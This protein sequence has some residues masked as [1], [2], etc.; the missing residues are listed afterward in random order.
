MN[1]NKKF[2]L[3]GGGYVLYA[4]DYPRFQTAPGFS[5]E[6]HLY[7]TA[8][9]PM[10]HLAFLDAGVPL[11]MTCTNQEFVNG[12]AVLTFTDGKS[13][14]VVEERFVTTDD[15]CVSNVKMEVS[16]KEEREIS[17]V[18]WT[19]TDV[20]G[21]APSL[22]GDS[23]RVRRSLNAPDGTAIPVEIIWSSPSS[24]GAKCLQAFHG[25]GGSDR[26]DYEETPWYDMGPEFPTP[27]AKRPMQKPS[28]I[29]DEA[30]CYLGLFRINKLKGVNKAEHRFEANVVFKGSGINYRPRRPDPKD[31][32]NYQ[33]LM[34]KAP[35]FQ[36]ESKEIER[37]VHA[38]YRV[39][40]LEEAI[41]WYVDKF[42][43][44]H[45]GGGPSRSGG[46]NA[47]VNFGQVQVEL[48]EPGDPATMGADHAMDH[49]GY[50]VGDIPSCI[51]TCEA[52]GLKFVSDT[53]NT[54]SVGQQVLYFDTDTSMGSRMHLTRLP[55]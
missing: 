24:K 47:F 40:D 18:Q 12:K 44:E 51:G 34:S 43:G 17:V 7:N 42:D 20:E 50:A 55:D 45:L 11:A 32:N 4:P 25:L 8:V 54:N 41:K 1:Q 49:V 21:E 28:P 38:G 2:A 9:K 52:H 53:P 35:K 30:R 22:E 46:R 16:G 3:G 23:F 5:D 26:P 31:E 6:V 33:A 19:T 39:K 13:L 36:C 48:I 14:T 10:F 29:V 15:R 27:R 37:I